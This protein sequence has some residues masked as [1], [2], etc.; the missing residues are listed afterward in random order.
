MTT[1]AVT[2][3]GELYTLSELRGFAQNA[4]R[5]TGGFHARALLVLLDSIA[6]AEAE[7]RTTDSPLIAALKNGGAE[8]ITNGWRWCVWDDTARQLVVYERKSG[9]K[10]TRTVWAGTDEAEAE[11]A[12]AGE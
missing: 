4:T 1:T 9:Q 3:N 7:Q 10:Y 6:G 12:L 5:G 11:N 8:R 2:V